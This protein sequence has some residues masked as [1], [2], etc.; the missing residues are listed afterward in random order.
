MYGPG[1]QSFHAAYQ[2]LSSNPVTLQVRELDAPVVAEAR[3]T[4]RGFLDLANDI[5]DDVEDH[6][7]PDVTGDLR[8]LYQQ[9]Q[10]DA[11]QLSTDLIRTPTRA[12]AVLID[13][14]ATAA[15]MKLRG[16]FHARL[17][18]A[19][20][21]IT[22]QAFRGQTAGDLRSAVDTYVGSYSAWNSFGSRY[23]KITALQG[24][25]TAL[26]PSLP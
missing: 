20:R 15:K 13:D 10:V 5:G 6:L 7:V 18:R 22:D 17:V 4:I 9:A 26:A 3:Q 16:D 2:D 14:R 8:T 1:E 25:T 24:L 19:Y 12:A 21:D 23:N 11:R